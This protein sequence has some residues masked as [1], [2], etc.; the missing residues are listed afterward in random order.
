M[1]V[2]EDH[3]R[4]VTYHNR[5]HA[6]DVVQSTHVLLNAP[7]LSSVFTDLEVL[8]V[9][10]ACAVH[11]VDHPGL[12]NQ[13]LINSSKSY[14][15]RTFHIPTKKFTLGLVSGYLQTVDYWRTISVDFGWKESNY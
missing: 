1:N 11:D 5:V 4:A 2:V 6:A 10:F 14:Y 8:A 13:Y 3:Y 15:D 7:A 9:L 12:T